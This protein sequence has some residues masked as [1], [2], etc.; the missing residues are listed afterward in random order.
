MVSGKTPSDF[1]AGF[2]L[3]VHEVW[4]NNQKTNKYITIVTS[5]PVKDL[6]NA[7]ETFPIKGLNACD[8]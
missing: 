4:Q 2:G 1:I 8:N 3:L 7:L 6:V 5:C